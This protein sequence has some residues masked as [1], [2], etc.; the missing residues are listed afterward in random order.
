MIGSFSSKALAAAA[1]ASLLAL[2][3]TAPA[4][5][6]AFTLAS[7]PMSEQFSAG[8]VDK[9]YWCRWG[10]CYGGW[11]YRRWGYGYGYHP[12]WGGP[13]WGPRRH[14]WMSPWGWRCRWW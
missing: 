6:S 7:P 11:G 9:A 8:Q 3:L 13:Y 4:P 12:Y 1:G 2:T 10:R 14:C 5:A